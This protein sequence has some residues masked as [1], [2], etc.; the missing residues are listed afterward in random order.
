MFTTE[1]DDI[2]A[3]GSTA[4]PESVGRVKYTLAQTIPLWGKRGLERG[5]AEAE[6][7]AADQQ[8]R[9]AEQELAWRIK[10]VFAQGYAAEQTMRITRELLTSLDSIARVAVSRYAQGQG[11]QQDAISAE[12]EKGRLQ[13]DLERLEAQRLATAARLNALLNRP[14]GSPLVPPRALR[15]VP[16]AGVMP[17]EEMLAR[18]RDA[19]PQLATARAEITASERNA[20]LVRR[21]WY[22]DV[23]LGVTVYDE[24][25][26][27]DRQFGGYEAMVS[28][29]VPLQWGLRRAREQD[30][31]A[32]LAAS[33]ARSEDAEAG[34]RGDIEE[35]WWA[36]EAAR[37]SEAILRRINVPQAA[38]LL[39]STL[40]SYELGQADL[41][42]VLLAEQGVRRTELDYVGVLVEQ[43]VRLADLERLVGGEL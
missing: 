10:T 26:D 41:P 7:G 40:A 36:L 1:I 15:P 35:A 17:L 12:A 32:K 21:S 16:D 25:G 18:A 8:R 29:D 9:F 30:A 39:R 27:N 24:D 20:E 42:G 6:A 3:S 19:N 31:R 38:V 23:T 13:L 2:R 37:R 33:R 28:L 4:A 34:L 43:Q 5:V 14:A 11:N 22:P